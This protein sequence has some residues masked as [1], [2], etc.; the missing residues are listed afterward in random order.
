MAFGRGS[1]LPLICKIEVDSLSSNE[2]GE[3]AGFITANSSVDTT[4]TRGVAEHHAD[5]EGKKRPKDPYLMTEE[6]RRAGASI[7]LLVV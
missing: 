6:E 5:E 2:E 7:S 4:P 1:G 3:E